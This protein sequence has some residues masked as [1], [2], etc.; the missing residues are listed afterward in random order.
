MSDVVGGTLSDSKTR[1]TARKF[2]S[3]TALSDSRTSDTNLDA[4]AKTCPTVRQGVIRP[5]NPHNHADIP[6]GQTRPTMSDTSDTRTRP[7]L[8]FG[9]T[10]WPT[11]KAVSDHVRGILANGPIGVPLTEHDAFLRDFLQLHREAEAKVGVGIAHFEIELRNFMT[12]HRGFRIVRVDGSI[13]HFGMH[14]CLH[15]LY[16]RES[17]IRQEVIDACRRAVTQDIRYWRSQQPEIVVCPETGKLLDRDNTFRTHVD[18]G[19]PDCFTPLV[20]R[21]LEAEGLTFEA[22]P[23][24]P[25]AEK[26]TFGPVIG[27]TQLLSRWIVFHNAN[28]TL[29]LVDTEWNRKAGDRQ[30]VHDESLEARCDRFVAAAISTAEERDPAAK[31]RKR[32][33]VIALSKALLQEREELEDRLVRGWDWLVAHPEHPRYDVNEEQWLRWNTRFQYIGQTLERALRGL[34]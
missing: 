16:G 15:A 27:N 24:L 7:D 6:V 31:D 3:K 4:S 10:T 34:K 25:D 11:K 13:D 18:H 23:L 1:T 26:V 30:P 33:I 8:V 28:A 14:K 19:W 20:E 2:D 9:G 12:Q 22:F 29:R 21:F 32:R 5:Q 17:A